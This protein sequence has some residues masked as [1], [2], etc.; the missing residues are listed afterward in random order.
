MCILGAIKWRARSITD[1]LGRSPTSGARKSCCFMLRNKR[2]KPRR[3]SSSTKWGHWGTGPIGRSEEHTSELQ[4]HSD[5]VCRL[6][7]E[8]KNSVCTLMSGCLEFKPMTPG[9]Y[10]V[11]VSERQLSITSKT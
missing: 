8:K 6:L 9:Y 7:L 3:W 2:T 11:N 10:T 1:R 4:S 5:L